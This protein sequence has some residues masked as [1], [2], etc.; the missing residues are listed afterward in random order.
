M[1]RH[2]WRF[3][4]D[5]AALGPMLATF[6][7]GWM[8]TGIG[9]SQPYPTFYYV[10]FLLWPLH[11]V[12][13]SLATVMLIVTVSVAIA[14]CSA[15][16]IGVL[17][18]NGS[19]GIALA[20]FSVLNPWVY[21]EL[22][23]GHIVMVLAYA[24]LLALTAEIMRPQ[25]RSWALMV[26]SAFLITQIEFWMVAIVPFIVWCVATRRYSLIAI[27]GLSALPIA[28]GIGGSYHDLIGTSYNL[29]WQRAQSIPPDMAVTLLGYQFHYA[30]AFE[31][32]RWLVAGFIVLALTGLAAVWRW[33]TDRIIVAIA[34]FCLLLATGTRGPL[35]FAYSYIV[36]H[37]VES[38]VF[39]ELFDLLA[40][41][42]IGYVVLATHALRNRY[43][44]AALT[45]T[46]V[47][48]VVPWLQRPAY[49]WFVPAR[50]LP[51]SAAGGAPY[52]IAYVPAFQPLSYSG[53][54]SGVD[55]DTFAGFGKMNAVNES[56]PAYPV[57]AAL[58][59]AYS[60]NL[61]PL[62]QLSVARIV[63]RPEFS[64]DWHVLQ[65]QLAFRKPVYP[66]RVHDESLQALPLA[67]LY[68]GM[69]Q[70]VSIGGVPGEDSITP[71]ME[72]AQRFEP[73][74]T[75]IEPS[76]GW[77]DARAAFIERPAWGNPWGGV[78]TSGRIA[79]P[80]PQGSGAVLA[81]TSDALV[82][83]GGIRVATR[84]R[85]LHWWDIPPGSRALF[86]IGECI[87]IATLQHRPVAREHA[88][89]P[90]F[91]EATLHVLTP[92]LATVDLRP[93][94]LRT[95]RYNV[96]YDPHWIAYGAPM[97][98]VALDGV[99]NGWIVQSLSSTR[100]VVLIEWLAA[101]QL[102][103]E[104][105]ATLTVAGSLIAEAMRRISAPEPLQ[106]SARDQVE[107]PQ[108]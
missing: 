93:S 2:D 83:D 53:R 46:A 100:R 21:S 108:L 102:A 47:L 48:L 52:R 4:A 25:P 35:G 33:H 101:F 65:Y 32:W 39:R 28:V 44:A 82:N 73:D 24:L 26:L 15:Y 75:T 56:A 7:E 30:M 42:A 27:A 61:R 23:A 99:I 71:V 54:G 107:I 89:A 6:F 91:T 38:G 36:A 16:R 3:P 5:A 29:E 20:F 81:Q 22:V 45:A 58:A 96:R 55:P 1:L 49:L 18:G 57:D 88:T 84:T 106:Q 34:L 12:I 85:A 51:A 60:G 10:G 59:S 90:R 92:W 69:P 17:R 19:A 41:A 77:V 40:F 104:L 105:L 13:T 103:L 78:A 66:S 37:V 9:Q 50:L 79:L 76:R 95:L 70:T 87:A 14:C 80:L 63:L 68:P 31:A 62:S 64:T 43:A 11:F 67:V 72:S 86:C 97:Q 8:P 74:R 98:H 94:A